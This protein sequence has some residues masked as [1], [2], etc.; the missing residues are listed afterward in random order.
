MVRSLGVLIIAVF[1]DDLNVTGNDN[2]QFE[3]VKKRMEEWFALIYEGRLEYYLGVEL[4]YRNATTRVL[5]LSS[6]CC[7]QDLIWKAVIRNQLL[8]A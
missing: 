8:S 1:V 6:T 2:R 5:Q 3:Y 4:E 7:W